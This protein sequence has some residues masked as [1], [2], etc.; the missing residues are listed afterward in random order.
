MRV[1]VSVSGEYEETVIQ[2]K[3]DDFAESS[4]LSSQNTDHEI[5]VCY[6]GCQPGHLDSYVE[7]EVAVKQF[8][9]YTLTQVK[10]SSGRIT[11]LISM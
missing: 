9:I 11:V 10:C 1:I 8:S 2:I 3:N 6:I 4:V 7:T 5:L